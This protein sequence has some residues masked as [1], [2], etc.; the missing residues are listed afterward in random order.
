MREQVVCRLAKQ[1]PK[2]LQYKQVDDSG[3]PVKRDR[4]GLKVG[5]IYLRKA[6]IRGAIPKQIAITVE[7]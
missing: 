5:N 1:T 2:A 4:D 3:E 7:Y 6:T